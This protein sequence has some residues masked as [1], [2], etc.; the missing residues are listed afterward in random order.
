MKSAKS[1]ESLD[2]ADVGVIW[3]GDCSNDKSG[4]RQNLTKNLKNMKGEKK[5]KKNMLLIIGLM[6][7]M[8]FGVTGTAKSGSDDPKFEIK[9]GGPPT[10]GHSIKR[11]TKLNTY[12]VW[13][14]N[15]DDAEGWYED[16]IDELRVWDRDTYRKAKE[17]GWS[18]EFQPLLYKRNIPS[19]EF[20]SFSGIF[21]PYGHY[22]WCP[23]GSNG[24]LRLCVKRYFILRVEWSY[25]NGMTSWEEMQVSPYS[26]VYLYRENSYR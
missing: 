3:H 24:R 15:A 26:T 21:P 25:V 4:R 22:A 16:T 20:V 8:M 2:L 6:V 10:L 5:M 14:Y 12:T 9:S 7:F 23:G 17:S 19:G 18:D 1:L 13:F 11:Y